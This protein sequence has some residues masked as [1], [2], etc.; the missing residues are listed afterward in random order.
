MSRLI[1]SASE[2]DYLVFHCPFPL[3]YGASETIVQL[4]IIFDHCCTILALM[5][6]AI[7]FI[8]VW[9]FLFIRDASGVWRF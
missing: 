1:L 7:G 5:W 4:G 8:C 2:N 6:Y 9:F 3:I